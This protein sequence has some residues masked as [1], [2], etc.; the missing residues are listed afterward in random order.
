MIQSF[1]AELKIYFEQGGYVMPPLIVATVVLWTAIGYRFSLL[2]RGSARSV[3]ELLRRAKKGKLKKS[4]GMI[5]GA[6]LRGREVV[7]AHPDDPRPFL[8]GAFAGYEK[9]LRTYT[10]LITSIIAV[11]P[12]LG[13]L[14]TVG[15]MIETFDSLGDMSLYSQSGGI[16]GG[17]SQ[18]LFTTQMGL[19]VAIPGLLAKGYLDR[20]QDKMEMELEQVKDLLVSR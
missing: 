10:A 2:K 6:V 1:L 12:L 17:I 13:L 4:K 14:G 5:D 8:D 15:G 16:A 3:R 7:K 11:A 20:R 19:A 18:A 9:E